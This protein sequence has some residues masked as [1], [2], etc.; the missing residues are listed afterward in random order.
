MPTFL[1]RLAIESSYRTIVDMK[2]VRSEKKKK[3]CFIQQFSFFLYKQKKN[4]FFFCA[5]LA[6]VRRVV[7]GAICTSSNV[8]VG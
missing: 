3:N 1:V 2:S 4:H 7:N 8:N 5:V 6:A